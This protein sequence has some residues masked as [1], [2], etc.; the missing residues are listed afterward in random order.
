MGDKGYGAAV[1]PNPEAT[2]AVAGHDTARLCVCVCVLYCEVEKAK[3]YG[4]L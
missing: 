2:S 4:N 1:S 3:L